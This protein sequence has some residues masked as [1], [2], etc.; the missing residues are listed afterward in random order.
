MKWIETRSENFP[1]TIH[2]RG[3]P[4]EVELA[5]RN[6]GKLLAQ[7][8]QDHRDIGAYRSSNRDDPDADGPDAARPLQGPG[9]SRELTEVYTNKTPTDA[10]R[11]A[12]PPG[13]GATSSSAV[14]DML[15]KK[16]NM[17]PA[18]FRRRTSSRRTSSPTPPR[19]ASCTTAVTTSRTW[20]RRSATPATPSCATSRRSSRSQGS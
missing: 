4:A 3:S 9:D 18:E 11:G 19:P 10:Y 13:G 12:G 15:A 2:G 5:A 16:L 1:A 8:D 17:D 6:D 7:R 14:M 20:T